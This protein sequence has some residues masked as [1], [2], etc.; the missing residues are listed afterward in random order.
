MRTK[1][2]FDLAGGPRYADGSSDT[3]RKYNLLGLYSAVAFGALRTSQSK[4][5]LLLALFRPDE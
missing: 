4:S 5:E 2:A 3:L 1:L